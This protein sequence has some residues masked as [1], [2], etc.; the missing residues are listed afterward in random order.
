MLRP[1]LAPV[2]RDAAAI[3]ERVGGTE[4]NF[5]HREC[6]ICQLLGT[7][8]ANRGRTGARQCQCMVHQL[9]LRA[10]LRFL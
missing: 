8:T 10:V 1:G 2:H 3:S 4:Q 7:A 6:A 5:D 9:R